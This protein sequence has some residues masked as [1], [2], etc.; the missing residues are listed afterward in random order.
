MQRGQQPCRSRDDVYGGVVAHLDGLD[1]GVAANGGG[2]GLGAVV[3][4]LVGTEVQG[5]DGAIADEDARQRG[6]AAVA[7]LVFVQ[8]EVDQ[9]GVG[10]EGVRQSNGACRRQ[11]GRA[12]ASGGA[13]GE[14]HRG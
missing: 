4:D 13:V 1:G 7:D 3:A 10:L 6:G 11:R 9:G 12:G 8:V 14:A 2:E 5:G